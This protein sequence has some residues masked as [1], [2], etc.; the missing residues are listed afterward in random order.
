MH[1][2][3]AMVHLM[4]VTVAVPPL[5]ALTPLTPLLAL[6]AVTI[7]LAAVT[8][9]APAA[10]VIVLASTLLPLTLMEL[11]Y[12]GSV[13]LGLATAVRVPKELTAVVVN[14]AA[15]AVPAGLLTM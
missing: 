13:A 9:L 1:R 6:M 12:A 15:M 2:L 11:T 4:M 8:A 5:E 10:M 3:P 14:A 7:L